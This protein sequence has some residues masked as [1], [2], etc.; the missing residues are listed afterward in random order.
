MAEPALLLFSETAGWRHEGGIAGDNVAV[1]EIAE[2]EGFGAFSTEDSAVFNADSLSRFGTV[3]FNNMTGD[4]LTAEEKT[5]FEAWMVAIRSGSITN[6]N[7]SARF[8]SVILLRRKFS[9]P[10]AP[11]IQ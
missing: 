10:F 5:A 11:Q 2:Q 6:A 3:V 1:H 7:C 8:S 9:H 4:T